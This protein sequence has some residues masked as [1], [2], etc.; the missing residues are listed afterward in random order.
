[1]GTCGS[2]FRC[3]ITWSV[4]DKHVSFR[5]SGHSNET[6][7]EY[8]VRKGELLKLLTK[9]SDSEIILEVMNGTPTYSH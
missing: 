6:P 2:E 3:G 1:M 5:K 7:S 8:F 4:T 9:L